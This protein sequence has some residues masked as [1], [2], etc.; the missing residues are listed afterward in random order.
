MRRIFLV[1]LL[2]GLSLVT[3]GV[4]AQSWPQRPVRVIV[5]FPPGGGTDMVAR[6][7]TTRISE[8]SGQP[9]IV[10]NRG[11]AAG[12]VGY[13]EL[14]RAQPD[15][16]TIGLTASTLTYANY[17]FPNLSFSPTEDLTPVAPVASVTLVLA[18]HSGF[19]AKSI[20]E[21]VSYA[22][23]QSA[24]LTYATPGV[25]TTHHLAGQ[26]LAKILGIKLVPVH[27]KGGGPAM[28]D[29]AAGHVPLT[30][31][32]LPASLPYVR[33]GRLKI[34][35]V[36]SAQR[37]K[38]APDLPTFAELGVQGYEASFWFDIR[39]PKGTPQT[40][41]DDMRRRITRAAGDP[42]VQAMMLRGGLEPMSVDP[43]D[44]PG[45]LK[46]DGDKWIAVIKENNI[47]NQ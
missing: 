36:A 35:A 11:G 41:I 17:F 45:M 24:P 25:G 46:A 21:V 20:G 27:Y 2:T 7:L 38:L 34:L 37:S 14:A 42:E 28:V 43:A 30:I 39:V 22:R 5:P 8:S 16:Y 32:G 31:I 15:G 13:A 3:S 10:E 40:V 1:V 23:S 18:A 12:N 9:F 47:T 33:D 26:L 44:Y 29:V 19:P 4:F 6:I